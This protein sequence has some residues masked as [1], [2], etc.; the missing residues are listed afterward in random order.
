VLS[1][2]TER[3]LRWADL[4]SRGFLPIVVC[5][6]VIVKRR[7]WGGPAPL[8]AIAPCEGGGWEYIAHLRQECHNSKF[9]NFWI[10]GMER[11]VCRCTFNR[12]SVI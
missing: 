3:S 8:G 4:S 10:I 5:L 11:N 6:S 2:V 1:A 9:G 12:Y 7:W